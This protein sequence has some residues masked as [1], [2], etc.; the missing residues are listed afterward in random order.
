ML[1]VKENS[2]TDNIY[3]GR[4]IN[5]YFE[6]TQRF[7]GD[8]NDL[9][10]T[11]ESLRYIKYMAIVQKSKTR[12][13]L[14]QCDESGKSIGAYTVVY[15]GFSSPDKAAAYFKKHFHQIELKGVC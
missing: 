1:K 5:L 8:H 10:V 13:Y 6:P 11:E 14:M 7:T 3:H 9:Q 12:Y 2:Y 4:G 15:K